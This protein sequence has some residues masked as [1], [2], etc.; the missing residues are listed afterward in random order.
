MKIKKKLNKKLITLRLDL[1]TLAWL[2]IEAKKNKCSRTEVIEHCLKCLR[3]K[4]IS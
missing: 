2:K 1:E 3:E 4:S